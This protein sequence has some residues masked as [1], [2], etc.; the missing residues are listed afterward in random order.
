MEAIRHIVRVS[1]NHEITIKVPE[2]IPKNKPVEI[3]LLLK[4][5]SELLNES[6]N[7]HSI[8]EKLNL[9]QDVKNRNSKNSDRVVVSNIDSEIYIQKIKKMREAMQDKLFLEDIAEV[10]EDFK[11]ADQDGW[12][13]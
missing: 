13:E 11:Y 1:K 4:D 3:I 8:S 10:S 5:E 9:Y 2:H 6:D 12:E 7:S